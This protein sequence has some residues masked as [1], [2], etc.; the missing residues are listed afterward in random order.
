MPPHFVAGEQFLL[1]MNSP[2]GQA[3]YQHYGFLPPK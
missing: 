1:F 2:A 3:I